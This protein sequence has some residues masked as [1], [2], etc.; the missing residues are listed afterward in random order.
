MNTIDLYQYKTRC[1]ICRNY[2]LFALQISGIAF[3]SI[4]QEFIENPQRE[5]K[6]CGLETQQKL[7]T[8]GK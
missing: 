2:N 7:V 6:H 3:L 1:E 5:C 4:I 8:Y